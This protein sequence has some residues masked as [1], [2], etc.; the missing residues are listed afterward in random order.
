MSVSQECI[1]RL[2]SNYCWLQSLTGLD[3]MYQRSRV[4]T[5]DRRGS[6][7]ASIKYIQRQG[8][9][10]LQVQQQPQ[11]KKYVKLKTLSGLSHVYHIKNNA[12]LT[13]CITMHN[14]YQQ[15]VHKTFLFCII[16]WRLNVLDKMGFLV[17]LKLHTKSVEQNFV[18]GQIEFSGLAP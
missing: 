17:N 7:N 6:G 8:A 1:H 14:Y 18:F 11:A 5:F 3:N 10:N 12:H 15:K 4:M 2:P 9:R 16:A 13:F